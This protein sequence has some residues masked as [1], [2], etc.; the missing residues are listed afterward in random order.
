MPEIRKEDIPIVTLFRA[1]GNTSDKSILE[2]IL[3][4]F[5]DAEMMERLQPS[6]TQARSIQTADA[7]QEYLGMRCVN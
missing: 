5:N 3:Y 6:L 1:L 2:R 7:A 4:E